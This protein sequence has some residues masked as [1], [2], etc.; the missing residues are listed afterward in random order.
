M[1]LE[2]ALGEDQGVFQKQTWVSEDTQLDITQRVVVV[3]TLDSDITVTLPSVGEAIGKVFT[4]HAPTAG[5]DTQA[6][7]LEDK[8]NDSVAWGGDFALD[9]DDDIIV[10]FSDGRIWHVLVNGISA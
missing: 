3:D 1:S 7:T 2:R 10:L 6:V 9:A 8:D 4:F 5:T